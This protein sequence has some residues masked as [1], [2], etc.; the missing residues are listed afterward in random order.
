[1]KLFNWLFKSNDEVI[2]KKES[3]YKNKQ[4]SLVTEKETIDEYLYQRTLV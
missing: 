4:Q 1:M 2:R 3:K